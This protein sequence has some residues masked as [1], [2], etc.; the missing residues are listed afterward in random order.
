MHKGG[1]GGGGVIAG[2]YGT[3]IYLPLGMRNRFI[4]TQNKRTTNISADL[5][6]EHLN[7]VC[8]EAVDHL[9]ANETPKAIKELEKS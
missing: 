1:G 5:H 4:N 2:F 8:K 7:R 9:G 3:I 6:I